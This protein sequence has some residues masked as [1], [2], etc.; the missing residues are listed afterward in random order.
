MHITK[1]KTLL[2]VLAVVAVLA[3]ASAVAWAQSTATIKVVGQPDDGSGSIGTTSVDLTLKTTVSTAAFYSLNSTLKAV[4]ASAYDPLEPDPTKESDS[5]PYVPGTTVAVDAYPLAIPP[6]TSGDTVKIRVRFWKEA[7][8][9][10]QVDEGTVEVVYRPELPHASATMEC[11][12]FSGSGVLGG[13]MGQQGVEWYRAP[14]G[15]LD[16]PTR[17]LATFTVTPGD[18]VVGWWF[19]TVD[20]NGASL[21][22]DTP[23]PVDI[24]DYLNAGAGDH[25]YDGLHSLSVRARS[26]AM[27]EGPLWGPVTFGIDSQD[28]TVSFSGIDPDAWS[29]GTLNVTITYSDPGGSGVD[30]TNIAPPALVAPVDAG[31]AITTTGDPTPVPV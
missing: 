22:G 14:S 8:Q 6:T 19:F 20:G 26:A 5:V 1:R 28:P 2:L 24:T 23:Q 16:D 11:G 30:G 10:N 3:V 29:K 4:G 18:I 25:P 31:A 7:A 21:P 12:G 27:V 9:I 17:A 13:V 15:E